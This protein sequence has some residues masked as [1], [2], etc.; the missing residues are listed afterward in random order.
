M[1]GARYGLRAKA[2]CEWR[3]CKG[4]REG[5]GA[6][7]CRTEPKCKEKQHTRALE[8][9]SG[10]SKYSQHARHKAEHDHSQS[11]GR[12]EIKFCRGSASPKKTH[13]KCG[14]S[15]SGLLRDRGCAGH[16]G[17]L[18]GSKT[19]RREEGSTCSGMT[20]RTRVRIWKMR[21][22]G[23]GCGRV[24]DPFGN[25]LEPISMR[26][27]PRHRSYLLMFTICRIFTESNQESNPWLRKGI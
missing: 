24:C 25:R 16:V 3:V 8:L 2:Q 23:A 22:T 11:Q 9:S 12:A 20:T 1:Q 4:A 7:A 19:R 6:R 14:G 21:G 17:G 27:M 10:H 15:P 26:P 13:K 18:W 5:G